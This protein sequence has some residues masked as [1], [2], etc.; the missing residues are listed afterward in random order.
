MKAV[1]YYQNLPINDADS[2]VDLTLPDPAPGERDLLVEVHA[3]SVNPVDVKIRA[4]VAP[5]AGHSK[6]IGWDAAGV[7]RAVGKDVTLFKPGDKVWYAGSLRRPGTNSELHLVD[8]RIV[9]RMPQTIDFAS[10]AALP[11][12]TITAWEL[13]FD[14]LNIRESDQ[15]EDAT[16]LVTG[17]AGGIGSILIQLARQ[18]TGLTVIGTAS[19]PETTKWVSDLG[20][21]YVIDHTKPLS[22]ELKRIGFT[23]VDYVASLN[24]TS[25]HFDEIVASLN[26]QGH[27][28]LIDDPDLLDFRKLKTKSVSLRWEFMFTRSMFSTPDQIRQHELLTRVGELIDAGVLRTTLSRNF[29]KVNAANLSRAHEWIETNRAHGKI[30]L[31]GF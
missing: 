12:T 16:L 18:L 13:L 5:E 2:L 29:G 31:E 4:G 6:V 30:V 17:A 28:A 14:R 19:R 10:A 11:L 27:L 7:V 9:G 24:Q 21:H 20:A 26:P 25:R 3:V 15:P 23:G 1:G 22:E 8:E